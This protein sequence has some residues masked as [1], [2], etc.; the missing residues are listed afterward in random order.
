MQKARR[1]T[2]KVLRPIVSTRFQ[3]LFTPLFGVLFTFP[4]RYWFTI[5][6]SGVF[7]LTRWC[8][9]IPTGFLRSR[10]TQGITSAALHTCTGL[11]PISPGFP[12]GS[13]SRRRSHIVTLQPQHC[14]NNIGLGSFPFARH[15]LGNHY[16][17][18]LLRLLRCFSSAR[19]RIIQHTFSMLGCPIRKSTDQ[20]IFANPRGL[21]QLI[22]SF[23][24]SESLGILRVPLFTFFAHISLLLIYGCLCLPSY[25]AIKLPTFCCLLLLIF[26]SICQRTLY[27]SYKPY[28]K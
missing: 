19:S 11:S 3:V 6:L 12:P 18:L 5:G 28:P 20:I 24:A 1:H 2:T 27:I 14:R 22:T 7:S 13:T 9:Q 25:I 4:S 8:W 17:F 26:L 23:I 15:Y 21:S 10:G 16:Y